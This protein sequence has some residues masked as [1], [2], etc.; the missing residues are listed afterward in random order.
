[1]YFFLAINPCKLSL[2][3]NQVKI[4]WLKSK[5]YCVPGNKNQPE[6][7]VSQLSRNGQFPVQKYHKNQICR[8][9]IDKSVTTNLKS[10]LY[11]DTMAKKQKSSEPTPL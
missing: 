10:K 1:M 8:N 9:K 2:K 11:E 4:P 3:A 5:S 6:S 7:C